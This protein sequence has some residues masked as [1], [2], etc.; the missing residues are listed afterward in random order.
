MLYHSFVDAIAVYA[1]QFLSPLIAYFTPQIISSIEEAAMF[2]DL[3]P[4]PTS[5]DAITQYISNV[6][7]FGFVLAVLLGMGAVAGE[8]ERGLTPMILSKP[9]FLISC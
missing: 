3:I 6:T 7:Q 9:N 2:A 8:K 1:A 5:R 4:E